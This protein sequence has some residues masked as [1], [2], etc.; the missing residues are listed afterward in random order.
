MKKVTVVLPT[1]NGEEFLR[2][3]IDSV[4]NQTYKEIQLIIV[5]DCSTDQTPRI[6]DAYAQKDQRV[7]VIHNK[8][9]QKLPR[10]LN[11][12]FAA[13][14]GD[15]W[16]WTSDDNWYE[17]EAIEKMVH[18]LEQHPA[19]GLVA[20]DFRKYYGESVTAM[21]VDVSPG[22]LLQD[23]IGAC[24]LYRAELAKEVGDYNADC[25]LAEDY[26]YW[27]RMGLKSRFGKINEILYHYRIH[28]KSLT[29]SRMQE[30]S[31]M[32]LRVKKNMIEKYKETYPEVDFMSTELE[33]LWDRLLKDKDAS[34]IAALRNL[35][36]INEIVGRLKR[37]FKH[38]G[39][40]FYTKTMAQMGSFYHLYAK[41]LKLKCRNRLAKKP[42]TASLP[43]HLK[44]ISDIVDLAQRGAFKWIEENTIPGAGIVVHSRQRVTYPEV[45]GY[46]IPTLLKYGEQ[47]RARAYADFLLTIQNED[48]SWNEPSGKIKYTFDT[49]QILKGLY[50]FSDEDKYR[51]ALV[52]G[53][54]W[55]LT[56]QREDGSIATPDYSWWGLP[57]G[58][59]VPEYIHLYCLEPLYK[60]AEK[61]GMEKYRIAA[62][63]AKAF[64]LAQPDLTDFMTLSHFNA[65]IIEA[66][67]DIG[68]SER[69]RK[70]MDEIAKFQTV[71]G[72]VPAY[73]H[74]KF[75]CSTGLFQYAI[76][77]YKLGDKDRGDKAFRYALNMQNKTGGWYGSY[78]KDANYFP[79]GE[80]AWAVKYF[81]DANYFRQNPF[82]R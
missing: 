41:W 12:G 22:H 5:D 70:A 66:L 47:K 9:N 67:I 10:S 26:E 3:S 43:G 20:A 19:E 55:L 31:E 25:F 76:C 48:G 46:Y 54:D 28:P 38:T 74:V 34:V 59:R 53:C 75:V 62:D 2:Q 39:D 57:Y 13:A 82:V 52:R 27:L 51:K 11:I 73:S 81:L 16:T 36:G 15:Y 23:T 49:A 78:G 68:E 79:D 4:L 37:E 14:E 44:E 64:Y 24:F 32:N 65:Y 60:V 29:G 71:E 1:Y 80:I 69:A 8:E 21:S 6:A 42:K 40:R 35:V 30:I 33:V 77:W 63:R 61:F 50:E 45:T 17:P 72:A 7:S 18:Y 56:M 58:K